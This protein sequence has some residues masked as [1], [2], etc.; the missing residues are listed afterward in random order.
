MEKK[1]INNIIYNYLW[2]WQKKTTCRC[3][4]DLNFDEIEVLI[5][6]SNADM[7]THSIIVTYY[8]IRPTIEHVVTQFTKM[9]KWY[10]KKGS[11]CYKNILRFA[12]KDFIAILWV[13]QMNGLFSCSK[14]RIQKCTCRSKL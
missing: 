8:L 12:F 7:K 5:E 4:Y 10:K 3:K 2:N 14:C 13:G 6:I 9:F 11:S 1:I